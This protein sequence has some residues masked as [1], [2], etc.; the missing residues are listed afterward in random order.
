M[1]GNEKNP[2]IS[3]VVPCYNVGEYVENCLKSL[4]NQTFKDIEIICV[5]DGS[6]DNTPDI[7]NSYAEKYS[8]IKVI[9]QE[10]GGLSNARN[11]GINEAR[12]KYIAF[13]DS[14]DWINE[15]FLENHYRAITK[16]DADISAGT[17]IRWRENYQKYRVHY[18]EEKVY[19]T[20]GEKIEICS[21]PK[22]CYVWN[23]LYKTELVKQHKFT[24]GVY[25]EDMLWTPGILK[26]SKKLVTVPDADYYYRVNKGSIVKKK[27]SNKKQQDSYN[28]HKYIIEFFEENNLALDK[29]HKQITKKILYLFNL[30]YARIKELD[31][32]D[33]FYLFNVL[34][35]FK[36]SKT[37][38]R[39]FYKIFGIKLTVRK[40]KKSIKEIREQN[41]IYEENKPS[42]PVVASRFETL[43]KLLNSNCSMSRYGDGEFNLIFG[44]GLPFQRYDKT[45]SKRLKEIL[46]SDDENILICIPDI[47]GSLRQ[48]TEKAA[49]FWRKFL[50]YNREDVKERLKPDK[51]YYDTEVTRPYMDISDKSVCAKYFEDFKNLFDGKELVIIEG[52]AS[53]LGIGNDLFERAKSIR[54][55]ICPARDAYSNYEN[56]YEECLKFSEGALYIAALGPAATVLAYDLAKTGRRTLDLGHADIEYEWF[57]MGVTEKVPVKDKYVNECRNGKVI[58]QIDNSEYSSQ[59]AADLTR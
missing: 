58:T 54:R 3:V 41:K 30:P 6:T 25:F 29:K 55:I 35:L 37:K 23:K 22:C 59:I 26:V 46:V 52:E 19:E 48:Y 17:I 38:Y 9:N 11:T 13:V 14:D 15:R 24:E 8:E 40:N 4:L 50:F 45:L 57:K 49:D 32:T 47:F 28:S 10:N 43:E 12:G 31:N 53:R 16:H 21:I 39:D 2:V 56:I 27:P 42:V 18:T 34:P 1:E 33:T 36:Y 44:E 5:N 20:L 7:L 51:K